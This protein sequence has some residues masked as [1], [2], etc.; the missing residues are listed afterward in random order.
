MY[1][2]R[3]NVHSPELSTNLLSVSAITKNGDRVT[4]TKEEVI[5]KKENKEVL[6]GIR[7]ENGFYEVNLLVNTEEKSHKALE[8]DSVQKWHRKLGHLSIDGMKNLIHQ[9]EG[10]NI[11]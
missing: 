4:F 6:R 9:S 11:K 1:I 2:K 10:M 5:V 7:E 3:R 8:T